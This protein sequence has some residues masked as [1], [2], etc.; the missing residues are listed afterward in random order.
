MTF[1]QKALGQLINRCTGQKNH[2]KFI[3]SV[4]KIVLNTMYKNLH[5]QSSLFKF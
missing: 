2:F 5:L 4:E 3:W 1:T